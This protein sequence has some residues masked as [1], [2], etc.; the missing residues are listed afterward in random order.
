MSDEFERWGILPIALTDGQRKRFAEYQ[1]AYWGLGSKKI[2]PETKKIL[3]ITQPKNV[4]GQLAELI[5]DINAQTPPAKPPREISAI[6]R[7][8]EDLAKSL[9]E[10]GRELLNQAESIV[11]DDAVFLEA[12]RKDITERVERHQ[13]FMSKLSTY[14][15][16]S[17]DARE[18][19]HGGGG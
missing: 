14:R 4:E 12:L 19:F 15:E 13:E 5:D 2:M 10:G 11:K 16:N 18:K 7:L 8:L 1:N 3:P 9:S 17:L 6:E